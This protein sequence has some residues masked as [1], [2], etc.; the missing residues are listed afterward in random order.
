M[1]IVEL[2]KSGV[3]SASEVCDVCVV[4]AGAAGLYLGRRLSQ[5]GLSVILLEA[6]GSG[7]E[8]GHA[9]GIEADSSQTEYR[10]AI[11]G[12]SFGLGG[13]TR[14]WGGQL[15]P[16]TTLDVYDGDSGSF[17]VWRHLAQVVAREAPVVAQ[18][19][20]LG[21]ETDLFGPTDRFLGGA[22]SAFLEM[23]MQ[24]VV[25][26]WLPFRKRNLSYLIENNSARARNLKVY[27]RAV[28]KSWGVDQASGGGFRIRHLKAVGP[29]GA[30][31]G[32]TAATYVIASG[33]IEAPRILL[34][35]ERQCDGILFP[36][37]TPVGRYLS[38]HLSCRVAEIAAS[39]RSGAARIFGPRFIRGRMRSVRL[40]ESASSNRPRAFF[41]FVFAHEHSGFDVAR[42]VLAGMQARKL[43]RLS[44]SELMGAVGGIGALAWHRIINRRLYIASNAECS[45]QMDMEQHRAESNC[46]LLG[47]EMDRYGRPV[48]IIKWS[49]SGEDLSGMARLANAF[50]AKWQR[51]PSGLPSIEPVPVKASGFKPHDAFHPVGTCSMGLEGS[52]V[53]ASDLR[54]H[55]SSNLFVLSTA[56]FP[57]AGTANPTFS[58]LCLGETL[59]QCLTR[60]FRGAYAE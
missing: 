10:G 53:V 4:G 18:Q 12:R 2:G 6:G 40:V 39:G 11:A 3:T 59:A 35:M 32:V 23:G 14:V 7:C 33:A 37:G 16:H 52:S 30:E 20:G 46:V 29:S 56:V 8:D 19:L 44:A 42:K 41:H 24:P 49:A 48:P 28:A 57:T 43:P 25:S 50:I 13:T 1:R 55:G 58:M 26:D 34:E 15:V 54:V 27:L 5:A 17:N 45:V 21:A 22:A 60:E 36:A 47:R 51:L 31:L 9:A 38:D